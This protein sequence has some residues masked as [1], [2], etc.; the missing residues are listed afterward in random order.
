[1]HMPKGFRSPH[2]AVPGSLRADVRGPFTDGA[3][4]AANAPS[5]PGLRPTKCPRAPPLHRPPGPRSPLGNPDCRRERATIETRGPALDKRRQGPLAKGLLWGPSGRPL[6]CLVWIAAP[7]R[8]R[9]RLLGFPR[10]RTG[11]HQHI[12]VKFERDPPIRRRHC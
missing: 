6:R 1:M 2:R 3:A 4:W 8:Q 12:L 7:E 9:H 5:R 11:P 10:T